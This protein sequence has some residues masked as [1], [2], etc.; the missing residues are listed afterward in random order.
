M[1]NN[2]NECDIHINLVRLNRTCLNVTYNEVKSWKYSSV[3]LL[4]RMVKKKD[5]FYSYCFATLVLIISEGMDTEQDR[6][7]SG[8]VTSWSHNMLVVDNLK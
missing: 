7:A 3:T 1:Y 8:L 4:S 2:F 6:W 5:M